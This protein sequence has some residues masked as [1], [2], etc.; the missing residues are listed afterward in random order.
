MKNIL[1]IILLS[2]FTAC[3]SFS[4]R[5]MRPVRDAIA[6]QVPEIRLEKEF[7]VSIGSGMFNLLN[8]ITVDEANLSDMD[9]VQVAVYN[10][11]P[12]DGS[13]NFD[14]VDFE[15]TLLEKDSSLVWET[16]IRVRDP[17][18][19]VWVLV[20]MN[21]EKNTLEAVTIF[22]LDKDQLVLINVDGD[23]E[24]MLEFALAPASSRRHGG[25]EGQR[26]GR[27]AG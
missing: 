11:L 10:V 8:V 19:Q 21:I 2:L 1:L 9:S 17:E 26:H 14:S 4:D 3:M 12:G 23:L 25:H 18:E 6:E 15:Q 5:S 22:Q 13:I 27:P 20:G 16:I 7:A 24:E